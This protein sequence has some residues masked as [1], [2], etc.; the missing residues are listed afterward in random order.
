[1]T[2]NPQYSTK[3]ALLEARAS[4]NIDPGVEVLI[5][6][7]NNSEEYELIDFDGRKIW[8]PLINCSDE[9]LEKINR[10]AEDESERDGKVFDSVSE[11]F[12]D[13]GIIHKDDEDV[14]A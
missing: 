7:D 2:T 3:N 6:E 14:P 1:M 4:G 13:M 8:I 5:Y 10:L 11:M 12:H 9:K